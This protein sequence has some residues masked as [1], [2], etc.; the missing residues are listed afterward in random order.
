MQRP[1]ETVGGYSSTGIHGSCPTASLALYTLLLRF[2][3]YWAVAGTGKRFAY[4]L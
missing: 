4:L 1:Y 2:V 3:L